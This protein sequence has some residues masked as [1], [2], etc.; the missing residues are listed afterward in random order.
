MKIEIDV[1]SDDIE[2]VSAIAEFMFETL[3]DAEPE[4]LSWYDIAEIPTMMMHV[5][6]K[7]HGVVS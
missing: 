4:T 2:Q 3:M 1:L 6:G 5:D 7:L